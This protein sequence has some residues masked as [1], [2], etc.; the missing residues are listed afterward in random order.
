MIYSRWT[1]TLWVL[2]VRMTLVFIHFRDSSTDSPQHRLA[3]LQTTSCVQQNKQRTHGQEVKNIKALAVWGSTILIPW[4]D[5]KPLVWDHRQ[6]SEYTEGWGMCA[7]TEKGV[8]P[9]GVK[10]TRLW[11]ECTKRSTVQLLL[12]TK[13]WKQNNHIFIMSN[14]YL[15]FVYWTIK[16]V[17]MLH[18]LCSGITINKSCSELLSPCFNR[19]S[20]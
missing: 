20:V 2:I 13:G 15:V 18:W 7:A 14:T 3:D 1:R 8:F 17:L 4:F 9:T 16:A 5:L 19:N 12:Q 6:K 11:S 10:I